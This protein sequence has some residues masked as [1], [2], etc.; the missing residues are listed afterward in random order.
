MTQQR[1]AGGNEFQS[2]MKEAAK[3]PGGQEH[4]TKSATLI[5][6]D[7][8][9]RQVRRDSQGGGGGGAPSPGGGGSN[10]R[11]NENLASYANMSNSATQ[12]NGNFSAEAGNKWANAAREQKNMN[13]DEQKGFSDQRITNNVDYANAQ[14]NRN[15]QKEG[16]YTMNKINNYTNNAKAHREDNTQNTTKVAN[17]TV[18][19]YLEMNKSKKYSTV[20]VARLDHTIRQAPLVDR[21]RSE[22]QGLK[23]FGDMYSYGRNELPNFTPGGDADKVETPDFQGIYNDT[24]N[25]INSIKIK[26]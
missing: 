12:S 22:T 13:K 7:A 14:Q 23:T 4:K 8:Y 15:F 3:G 18:N 17:R 6:A 9:D 24:R 26:K 10:S 20:D 2:K 16:E 11:M 25:D 19:K 5:G 1:M 21:A